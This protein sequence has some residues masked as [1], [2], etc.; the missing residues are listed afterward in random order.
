LRAGLFGRFAALCLVFCC[1][2]T[3]AQA[4][5]IDVRD[6]ALDPSDE[7]YEVNATFDFEMPLVLENL[8]ERGITL[9]FRADLEIFRPRWY[10][11]DERVARKVLTTRLSYHALTRQYRVS[12]GTLQQSFPTLHDA[13]RKLSRLRDWLVAERKDLKPGV[14]HRVSFRYFLDTTELPKPLQLTAFTSG[15]W[16]L[17]API[18]QISYTPPLAEGK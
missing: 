16:D 9:S 15:G 18:L 4:S 7:G 5:G 12:S 11:L 17:S 13:V 1:S 2:F 8:L 14:P 3:T 6:F 10:W